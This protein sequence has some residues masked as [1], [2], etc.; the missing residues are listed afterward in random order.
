MPPLIA[1]S[2]W[3]VLLLALLRFDPAR[4]PKSSWAL[5]VPVIWMF[6][7]GSRLASQWIEGR[8]TMA[9]QSAEEGNP[10]DRTIFIVLILVSIA[11]LA[12]RSFKWGDFV[13]RNL[14]LTSLLLFALISVMWSDFTFVALKR[15]FRDLE[16]YLAILVIMTDPRPLEAMRTVFR[17]VYYLLIPLSILLIKYFPYIG[18]Q[19]NYWTGQSYNAGAATS[20]N[21]LGIA[22]LVSGLFFFWDT[23]VRWSD[24]G[25]VRT[26]RIILVNLGFI[27]MTLW[28]LYA[29]ESATSTVCLVL[30]CLVVVAAHTHTL[31]R[32]P[33]LLTALI[34]S[35]FILY[36]VLAFG[37]GLNGIFAGAV[38]R[39]PTLTDRTQIWTILLS[40]H[41]NPFLGTGY[42]S[43]WLG[44]RMAEV[45]RTFQINEAHN[46][47]LQVYLNLGLI[48]LFLLV[49][50]LLA[51]YRTISKRLRP[52]SSL[53]SFSLG[54]WSIM[55]FYNMTEATFPG[56]V[57]WLALL[58]GA[59]ALAPRAEEHP[60]SAP[61][62]GDADHV[63][64][65]PVSV[66]ELDA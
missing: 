43:F 54:V 60:K 36:L 50:F 22:C 42:E 16:N 24:R 21:M 56:G 14:A 9:A 31:Q 48:G 15:W 34:P 4:E 49:A 44:S 19:F 53:G 41:T 45:W 61:T 1:L 58:P 2:I 23:V 5:W 27:A 10:L 37:L 28:L 52:F 63:E 33:R 11:I 7:A 65:I 51:S 18:R 30:G 55:L 40:I 47:Y 3:A 13:A 64:E 57:L 38:G 66:W 59:I 6:I 26:K 25:Q 39:N 20:K 8:V 62:L 35:A 29:A 32:S 12:S 46:G 17:R